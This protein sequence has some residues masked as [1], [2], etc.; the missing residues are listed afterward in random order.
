MEILP[1]FVDP[2]EGLRSSCLLRSPEISS[3]SPSLSSIEY[4]QVINEYPTQYQN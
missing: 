3:T 4:V 1:I 2:R